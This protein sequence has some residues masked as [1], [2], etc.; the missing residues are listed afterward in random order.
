ML[1]NMDF[2]TY[3]KL[4]LT[5]EPGWGVAFFRI[6]DCEVY[7]QTLYWLISSGLKVQEEYLQV[8]QLAGADVI[9]YCMRRYTL[10]RF[11]SRMNVSI[12][13]SENECRWLLPEIS[14]TFYRL[15]FSSV[16]LRN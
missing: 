9:A 6:G 15:W 1:E 7:N 8:K 12:F 13:C 5:A 10:E 2:R 14:H 16:L 4:A 11:L 3:R